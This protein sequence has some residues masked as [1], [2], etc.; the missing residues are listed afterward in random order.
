MFITHVIFVHSPEY[1]PMANKTWN[2]VEEKSNALFAEALIVLDILAIL[3]NE[4][5]AIPFAVAA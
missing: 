3:V 2:G 4:H 5:L 1:E